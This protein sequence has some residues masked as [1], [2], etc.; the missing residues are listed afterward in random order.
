M[1]SNPPRPRFWNSVRPTVP[2]F[3]VAPITATTFGLQMLSSGRLR[4]P[5]KMSWADSRRSETRVVIGGVVVVCIKMLEIQGQHI[6]QKP[7]IKHIFQ[8]PPVESTDDCQSR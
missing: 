2:G 1:P 5:R 8:V 6:V 4:A 7:A 3:S